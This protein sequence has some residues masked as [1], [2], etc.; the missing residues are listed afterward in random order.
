M[1]DIKSHSI[2]MQ[3]R[4]VTTATKRRRKQGSEEER[5]AKDREK[6]QGRRWVVEETRINKKGQEVLS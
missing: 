3:E 5:R 4:S 1:L 2:F 6:E